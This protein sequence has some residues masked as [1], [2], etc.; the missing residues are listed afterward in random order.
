M[1]DIF[2]PTKK[3]DSEKVYE[4][5]VTVTA[6]LK[7][8][9]ESSVS[10][11][12]HGDDIMTIPVSFLNDDYGDW[13]HADKLIKSFISKLK[14]PVMIIKEYKNDFIEATTP[15]V[16]RKF[17]VTFKKKPSLR[18]GISFDDS[19]VLKGI[20]DDFYYYQSDILRF[21]IF[22]DSVENEKKMREIL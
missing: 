1:L 22:D 16:I 12:C 4:G 9:R 11:D 3:D 21:I 17:K 7:G 18:L 5:A 2:K 13:K 10:K 8:N 19:K 14:N 15:D 6:W 20:S